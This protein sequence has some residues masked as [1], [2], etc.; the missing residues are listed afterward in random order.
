MPNFHL[1][2]VN[3]CFDVIHTDSLPNKEFTSDSEI[4]NISVSENRIV[5]TKD[6]DFLD[7]YY[8]KSISPKLLLVTTGNTR[9]RDLITLFDLHISKITSLFDQHSFVELSN[10]EIIGHE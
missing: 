5:I 2:C 9:N 7:S 1:L 4:R 10:E 6:A 3:I 8:I